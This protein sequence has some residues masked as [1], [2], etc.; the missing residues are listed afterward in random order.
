MLEGITAALNIEYF[1][2]GE[3]VCLYVC[4]I[5]TFTRVWINRVWQ[6][7]LLVVSW[8][9]KM[10]FSL[11]P[12]APENLVSRNGFGRPSPCQPAH[13]HSPH[14]GS[15]LCLPTRTLPL[16]TTAS[17]YLYRQPPS[18][19]S[20]VYRVA[21]LCT[22]GVHCREPTSTGSVVVL[23]VVRLTGAAF[24]SG[25]TMDQLTKL[26][27]IH[28]ARGQSFPMFDKKKSCFVSHTWCH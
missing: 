20:R 18:R 17:I 23:K 7:V 28:W 27:F 14:S 3:Y 16:S 10:F 22:D 21:Q 12:F 5:K 25:F 1:A 24:F 19:Q 15:I 2:S 9:G 8:T 26:L 4:M 11:S 6:P 13:Y